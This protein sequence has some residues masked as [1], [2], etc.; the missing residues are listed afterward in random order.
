MSDEHDLEL[1]SLERHYSTLNEW[2]VS[3]GWVPVMPEF[4]PENGVVA[5]YLKKPVSAGFI[6]RTDSAYCLLEWIISDP[7]SDKLVRRESLGKLVPG[8]VELAKVMG[9]KSIFTTSKSVGL[10]GR[11]VEAGFQVS[12]REMTHLLRGL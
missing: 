3:W 4:L 5:T 6:Y 12:D 7:K 1:F 9:F 10:T 8:L 2:W 11:L